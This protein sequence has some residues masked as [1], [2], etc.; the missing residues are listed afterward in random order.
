[1]FQKWAIALFTSLVALIAAASLLSTKENPTTAVRAWSIVMFSIAFLIAVAGIAT[2]VLSARDRPSLHVGESNS[3]LVEVHST[4]VDGGLRL[5]PSGTLATPD[6]DDI[7]QET[8]PHGVTGYPG[9]ARDGQD[10]FATRLPVVNRGRKTA[11]RVHVHLRYFRVGEDT[12][13]HEAD[14]KWTFALQTMSYESTQIAVSVDIPANEARHNF[15]VLARF[16]GE[17]QIYA[18]DDR[19]RFRGWRAIPLGPGPVRVEVTVQSSNCRLLYRSYVT[20]DVNTDSAVQ[21]DPIET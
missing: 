3:E 4:Q 17:D 11:K 12:P 1:M 14:A 10:F 8:G 13:I 21:L 7:L 20:R 18:I 16:V 9:P 15:D 2:L 6:D 19:S 5:R